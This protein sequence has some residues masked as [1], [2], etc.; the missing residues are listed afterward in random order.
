M[1]KQT[2]KSNAITSKYMVLF[3]QRSIFFKR[4]LGIRYL[5]I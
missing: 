2:N 3:G 5:G 1:D 4:T